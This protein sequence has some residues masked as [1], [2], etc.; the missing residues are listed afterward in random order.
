M[1][2]FM[3]YL[4]SL[5]LLLGSVGVT[6][7]PVQAAP[8]ILFVSS[9]DPTCAGNSP[10]Y[11]TIQAAV[12]VAADGVEIRVAAGTYN[13]AQNRVGASGY[14]YKQVVFTEKSI[15][16][17]GGYHPTTWVGPDP[18]TNPTI[19]DAQKQGRGV[20]VLGTGTQQ[21][22]LEALTIQN[23]DYTNLGN[24]EGISNQACKG[25]GSDCG[26]GLFVYNAQ[27]ILDNS[28]IRDN[29]ATTAQ[30]YSEGG[31][32]YLWAPLTGSKVEDTQVIGNS[33]QGEGG[34]GGGMLAYF[35]YGLTIERSMFIQNQSNGIGGGLVIHQ[36]NE[37]AHVK[38]CF[39]SGN[40]AGET[41][42]ALHVGVHMNGPAFNAERLKMFNN[43]A[44][45]DGAAVEID[46]WGGSP[47]S[48][49]MHNI[50]MGNNTLVHTANDIAVFYI[51]GGSG[52]Q[53][54]VE[55]KHLTISNLQNRAAFHVR[56]QYNQTVNVNL[57]NTLIDRFN[58]AF[59]AYEFAGEIN[60]NYDYTLMNSVSTLHLITAGSPTFQSSHLLYGDPKF[61]STFHLGYDSAAIDAGVDAGVVDDVDGDPRPISSSFDIGADEYTS[62]IYLPFLSTD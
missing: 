51:V 6:N 14:T 41:G 9:T 46:K 17:R 2:L 53:L 20:T 13:E 19:I 11:S 22:T 47:S 38:D 35:G 27:I 44:Y 24:P 54:D 45:F 7:L 5:V 3:R 57:T 33:L 16:I 10:C 4:F 37:E 23:G 34:F 29:V 61:T 8:A 48:V 28:I 52:A 40:Y 42:G 18:L 21:V 49:K 60:I 43:Q 12:D 26:G 32:I 62:T 59:T 36:M 30:R 15:T 50:L 56:Q 58:Y 31:G 39:F 1:K 25:T 55:L